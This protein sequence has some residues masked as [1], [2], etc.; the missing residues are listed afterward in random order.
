MTGKTFFLRAVTPDRILLEEEV[1]MI[2]FRTVK[3][4]M[5]ILQGHEPCTVMLDSGV[6]RVRRDSGEEIYLVSGGFAMVDR[7]QVVVMSSLAEHADRMEALLQDIEAQRLKRKK[8]GERWES[9]IT[10][11]EI[12][13]RR[14]LLGQEISAYS[15]LKGKGEE[16]ESL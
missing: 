1:S 13:I 6:M 4:D 12:A 11:A 10:R 15:I 16:G 3:G 8:E 7:N 5:G 9:E 2:V 14:V